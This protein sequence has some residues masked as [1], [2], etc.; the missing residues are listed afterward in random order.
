MN[1]LGNLA[2]QQVTFYVLVT[3]SDV[4]ILQSALHKVVHLLKDGLVYVW[5]Y[6]ALWKPLTPFKFIDKSKLIFN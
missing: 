2:L 4:G 1:S 6:L 3:I 5:L